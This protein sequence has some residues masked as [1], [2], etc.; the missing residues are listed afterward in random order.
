MEIKLGLLDL[1]TPFYYVNVNYNTIKP[2]SEHALISGGIKFQEAYD[3]HRVYSF[4][5]VYLTYAEKTTLETIFL[6]SD[7]LNV[8]FETEGF[9][10]NHSIKFR[11]PI[12][13]I[14]SRR[15]PPGYEAT[16]TGVEV[17]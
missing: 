4:E 3:S 16:I 2:K 15:L 12:S 5:F 10:I 17:S 14:R 11:N 7:I 8:K 13:I 1:E 6:L 9:D